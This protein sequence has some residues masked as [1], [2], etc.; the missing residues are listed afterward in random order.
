MPH[1]SDI[2]IHANVSDHLKS[3]QLDGLVKLVTPPER[4][5]LIRARLYG[6]EHASGQVLVFLDSHVEPNVRWLEPLLARIKES[7]THVVTPIIDVINADTFNYTPSPLVKGG[8]NWGLNF[9]W[10]SIP[11]SE[12]QTDADYAKPFKSPT[13][14]GGLFAIDKTYFEQVLCLIMLL[15]STRY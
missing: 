8:F 6:A 9:K 14:A 7:R 2:D 3:E 12:L 5:G 11:R 4:S 15:C 13:M 1:L 10:D